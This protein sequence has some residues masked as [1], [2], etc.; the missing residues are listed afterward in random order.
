MTDAE[1][2]EAMNSR[3]RRLCPP[4]AREVFVRHCTEQRLVSA[5]EGVMSICFLIHPDVTMK[6]F[7][8][9]RL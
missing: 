2:K 8:E 4:N 1:R 5:G 3:T 9:E 7:F 6:E